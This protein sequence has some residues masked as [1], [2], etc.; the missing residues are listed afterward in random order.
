MNEYLHVSK[1][2]YCQQQGKHYCYTKSNEQFLIF[3]MEMKWGT[4]MK[5]K[6]KFTNIF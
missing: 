4:E 2:K 3:I 5:R 1:P 6:N